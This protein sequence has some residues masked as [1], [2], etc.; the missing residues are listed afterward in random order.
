MTGSALGQGLALL[1][2]PI[3]TR[4]F[5]PE[6]FSAFEQY[7]FLLSVFTVVVTGKYEFAI[8]HPQHRDDA[9]HLAGLAMRIA[10]Y[11]CG[12]ML[13]VLLFTSGMIAEY[14]HHE[15]LK[16]LLWTLPFVLVAI[17][18][19]NIVNFW[20]SREK[21][22]KIAAR[23]KLLYSAAGEPVKVAAGWLQTG[24][25]GL[26]VGTAIGH[27]VAAWYSWKKFKLHEPKTF[28]HLS[29]EKLK[30]LGREHGDY[31][32]YAIW[33]GVLNNL[34][35]WAHV[36]VFTF[37]YGEKAL[38]PIG[39]IA[40]S[41]RIFFNPLGIL[42]SSY[43]QVFY[44]R[45]SEIESPFELRDFYL[46]N[47]SRFLIFASVM[48]FIVQI[49]P[50]NSIG[51]I[52]GNAWTDALIYLKILSYWYALN[53][54]IGT[55]S[56]IFYRLQLQWYTLLVD[57]FH[58]LI[59]IAAFWWAWAHGMD[60]LQAVKAMVW[61]KVFYLFLNGCAVIYFLNRNCRRNK[62]AAI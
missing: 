17:A 9:R 13:I 33:G 11:V 57:I 51:F 58:F 41:R 52:F 4:L 19:F 44:Q 1:L 38:I 35:Q 31:P 6:D 8:M 27:F 16:Y 62:N 50:E 59:V 48:V 45:I 54:V 34:A 29:K 47:L 14:V 42:S 39:L 43:G 2:S 22:Y 15:S 3:I 7:A 18:V 40:L 55:L 10:L 28:F 56:F 32:R 60:E 21:N 46:K 20:F 26:I 12:V 25:G 53:F 36:A 24:A 37:F 61:A 30:S 5:T 49:L 23:S